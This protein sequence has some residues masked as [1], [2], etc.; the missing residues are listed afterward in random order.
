[1]TTASCR[2]RR[3]PAGTTAHPPGAAHGGR[4]TGTLIPLSF[5]GGRTNQ[6]QALSILHAAG[7]T[8]ELVDGG[9]NEIR[10]R[11]FGDLTFAIQGDAARATGA[12]RDDL[13]AA[14]AL[15]KKAVPDTP[16]SFNNFRD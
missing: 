2:P 16:L 4:H 7:L 6:G 3:A 12:K 9:M 1:M 11:S 13:Q 5:R 15:V 10:G 8:F 14:M